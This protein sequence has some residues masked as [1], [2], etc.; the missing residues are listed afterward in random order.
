M[1]SPSQPPSRRLP[2]LWGRCARLLPGVVRTGLRNGSQNL[3]GTHDG[4]EPPSEWLRFAPARCRL[5][6]AHFA[7]PEPV[8]M[9]LEGARGTSGR[10]LAPL[11]GEGLGGGVPCLRD[12]RVRRL[13][14]V[15]DGRGRRPLETSRTSRPPAISIAGAPVTGSGAGRTSPRAQDPS[16]EHAAGSLPVCHVEDPD[17]S[18]RVGEAVH[19]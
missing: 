12:A 16:S 10:V 15:L 5:R 1:Q 18:D 6:A 19:A 13:E 4:D 2:P 17:G 3:W 11:E 14:P 9:N 8:I 7:L